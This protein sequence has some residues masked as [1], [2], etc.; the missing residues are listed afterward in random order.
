MYSCREYP[1]LKKYIEKKEKNYT[2]KEYTVTYIYIYTASSIT[3]S[4]IKKIS[5][6]YRQQFRLLV[7][8]ACGSSNEEIF[9]SIHVCLFLLIPPCTGEKSEILRRISR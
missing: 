2:L 1:M 4:E 5:I 3:I 6:N 9:N 8:P 7:P